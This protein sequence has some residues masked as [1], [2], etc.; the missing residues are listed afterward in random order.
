MK[1]DYDKMLLSNRIKHTY[2]FFFFFHISSLSP[3]PFF[4]IFPPSP[5]PEHNS[6]FFIQNFK[7]QDEEAKERV[8]AKNKLENYAFTV[9]NSTNDDTL[10]DK[11]S[12]ED[13]GAITSAVEDTLKW[14]DSNQGASKDEFDHRYSE[15]EK[16][17][18]PIMT[19]LYQQGG[20]GGGQGFPA[21][22]PAPESSG[23][24]APTVEEVD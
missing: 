16:K 8:E 9:K 18:N 20:A 10:K 17:V 12:S 23:R 19:K 24:G 21:G 11:L 4:F 5:L 2:I 7:K 14:L 1:S 6:H 3:L 13:K 15:L 22:G